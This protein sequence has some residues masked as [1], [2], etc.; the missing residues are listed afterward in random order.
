MAQKER[1]PLVVPILL[2][3]L[4]A[5]FLY[6]NYR[7]AF[8]PWPVLRTYWPLIL[9]FVGLGKIWDSAQRRGDPAAANRFSFGTTLGVLAFVG[10]LLL[11]LWHGRSYSREHPFA[12]SLHHEARMVDGQNAKSV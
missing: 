12:A 4:G 3:A 6:A 8:D 2:I 5:I 7:P 10:V 9:I 11:L 1:P